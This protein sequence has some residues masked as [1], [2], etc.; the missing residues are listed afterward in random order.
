MM[1]RIPATLTLTI[2]ILLMF[3]Y[4]LWLGA[5]IPPHTLW[6][7]LAMTAEQQ[8]LVRAGAIFGGMSALPNAWRLLASMFI[9]IGWVH[10]LSNVVALLQIGFL[11]EGLFGSAFL[12]FSFLTSGLLAG[13]ASLFVLAR[14]PADVAV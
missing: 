12:I 1:R 2:L 9:H 10:L 11:L 13:I 4:E 5:S 14:A 8:V 6:H 3:G 7:A